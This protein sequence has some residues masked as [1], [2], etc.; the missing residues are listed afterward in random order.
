[1]KPIRARLCYNSN[2]GRPALQ[3]RETARLHPQFLDRI[4]ERRRHCLPGIWVCVIN[5]IKVVRCAEAKAAGDV[6]RPRLDRCSGKGEELSYVTF[7]EWQP[8]DQLVLKNLPDTRTARLGQ[9]RIRLH[10]DLAADLGGLHFDI[11]YRSAIDL[12]NDSAL[13]ICTEPGQ[14]RLELIRTDR[15]VRQ[16]VKPSVIGNYG[17]DDT[18][19]SLSDLDGYACEWRPRPIPH[20]TTDLGCRLCRCGGRVQNRQQKKPTNGTETHNGCAVQLPTRADA[21][22][23]YCFGAGGSYRLLPKLT[24]CVSPRWHVQQVTA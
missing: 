15:E 19:V 1:M 7:P 22:P 16:H 24:G 12:Q 14:N 5:P 8:R 4:R 11:D 23:A 3:R 21:F 13:L 18:R 20:S 10:L 9:G 6:E 2:R 17:P